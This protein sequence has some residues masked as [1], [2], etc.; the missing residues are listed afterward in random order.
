VPLDGFE[1]GSTR[2]LGSTDRAISVARARTDTVPRLYS[3]DLGSSAASPLDEP[4]DDAWVLE[5]S[6]DNSWAATVRIAEGKAVAA[7]HPLAGGKPVTLP[8]LGPDVRPAGWA[9]NDE[10]WLARVVEADPSSFGLIR[11]D[12][13]RRVTLEQ[14][15]VSTSGPG[16]IGAVHVTPNGKNIVFDQLRTEGHLYVVRGLSAG[17]S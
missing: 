14:R 2:F 4:G 5:I 11:F 8:E 10:L 16:F 1:L 9:S 7:I 15:T 13:R 6:P 3:I 17:G 12:V